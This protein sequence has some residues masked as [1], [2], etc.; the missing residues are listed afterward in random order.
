MDNLYYVD[1]IGCDD[2]TRG[3]VIIPDEFFNAFKTFIENLN[4]NSTYGCMPRI[5]VYKI[6]ETMIREATDDD[7]LYK[8]MYLNDKKYVLTEGD[9]VLRENKEAR[10]I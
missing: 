6:D 1:N 7:A 5:Q 10:V 4:K 3:L 2:E 8:I 9:W